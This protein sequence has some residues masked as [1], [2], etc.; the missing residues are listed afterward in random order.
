MSIIAKF[1]GG[2]RAGKKNTLKNHDKAP[3]T[4]SVASAELK[5]R[6]MAP[7]KYRHYGNAASPSGVYEVY[8]WEA[9]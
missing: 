3:K 4:I 6:N 8:R 7:G 5:A 9:H 2:P 1:E